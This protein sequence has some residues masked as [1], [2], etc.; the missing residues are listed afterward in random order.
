MLGRAA[1]STLRQRGV[2]W[3]WRWRAPSSGAPA[4]ISLRLAS[5]DA[6]CVLAVHREPEGL[7]DGRVR[8]EP[9]NGQTLC[10]AAAARYAPLLAHLEYLSGREWTCVGAMR[11]EAGTVYAR[12]RWLRIGFSIARHGD[13]AGSA[14]DGE[15]LLPREH[16]GAWQA[17][18]GSAPLRTPR[19]AALPVALEVNLL[20]PRTF[21]RSAL[22]RLRVGGAVLLRRADPH[23]H[24]CALHLPQRNGHWLAHL[25]GEQLVVSGSLHAGAHPGCIPC[26]SS[27][28]TEPTAADSY[29]EAVPP[30]GAEDAAFDAGAMLDALPVTLEF[31]LGQVMLPL[32]RLGA[33]LTAGHVF[34]LGQALGPESVSVRANGLEVGRGELIQIGDTL[35]VRITRLAAL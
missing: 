32:D 22:Q 10:L 17:L 9:F 35:A 34:E 5:G 18:R 7:V 16:I 29:P 31:G 8:L 24:P 25:R 4:L 14:T 13:A 12:E 26:R 15:V 1:C 30:H 20:T 21:A 2:D 6:H 19:L 3:Q 23:G 28:M 27:D 33:G 11:P